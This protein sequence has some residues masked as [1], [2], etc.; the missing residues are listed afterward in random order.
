MRFNDKQARGASVA[1]A[2]HDDVDDGLAAYDKV[3][4]PLGERIVPRGR[5]I[6]RQLGVNLKTD[7]ERAMWEL[8]QDHRAMMEWIAAPNFLAAYR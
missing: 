5:K 4:Q 2:S 7:E 1:P 3:R 6:G 8:L